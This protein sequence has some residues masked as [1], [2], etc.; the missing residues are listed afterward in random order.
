MRRMLN[1]LN[2]ST[3]RFSFCTPFDRSDNC[4]TDNFN[5]RVEFIIRLA[6]AFSINAAYL[7][8]R[9][10]H[11]NGHRAH[12]LLLI[13]HDVLY[14][15]TNGTYTESVCSLSFTVTLFGHVCEQIVSLSTPNIVHIVSELYVGCRYCIWM[16]FK[17][18]WLIASVPRCSCWSSI[19]NVIL[20]HVELVSTF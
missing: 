18:C 2:I 16:C 6:N 4:L 13:G 5:C 9:I 3:Y 12:T 1:Q 15:H 10:A 14:V 20:L 17:L 8:E 11:S 19:A 7:C